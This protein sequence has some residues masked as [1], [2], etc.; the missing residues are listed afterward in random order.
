MRTRFQIGWVAIAL[1]FFLGT[2][3]IFGFRDVYAAGNQ[4]SGP[5]RFTITV[6]KYTSFEWWLSNW[7]DNT[8]VCSINVDHEGLPI[9]GE[10]L[11]ACGQ[12]VYD[13]WI[14]TNPCQSGEECSGFYL[15]FVKAEPAKRK[16]GVQQPPPVVWLR[17]DG[18]VPY[19]STFR[20]DSLPTLVLT[21]EE[22][23]EGEHI[24]GLAGNVDDKPFTCDPVCQVDLVPTDDDGISLEFWAN[25]SYGDSSEVYSARIRV[26]KSDNPSDQ[27]WYADVLS[28]QWR[29]DTLAGCSQIWDKFPPVGG[30]PD[31]LSTPQ[32][33]EE[34]ATTVSYEYL[35]ANLIKHGVVDTSACDGGGLLTNGFA[36]T[37]GLE[38]RRARRSM[39][40]KTVLMS[41]FFWLRS[42]PAH[43]LNYL[44]ISLRARA[45]SGRVRWPATRR[46][47]W[48][49]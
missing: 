27:A 38:D 49:R 15:Q 25:S 32:R 10:I 39:I 46:P 37:C 20:C 7:E 19:Q 31:W 34:L 36:N 29:G 44:R 28:T 23:I 9:G 16:V 26:A 11:D 17:L 13:K 5:D 30:V 45:N 43:R 33:P 41:L 2:L 24:T 22:P 35:A 21:G 1:F 6:Q 47:V 40:G 12:D 42:R 3:M 18:C 48:V 4:P 8:V 14:V